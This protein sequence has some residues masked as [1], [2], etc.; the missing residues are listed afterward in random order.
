MG[1]INT[2]MP[3]HKILQSSW[4]HMP[5]TIGADVFAETRDIPLRLWVNVAMGIVKGKW[6]KR[7][8]RLHLRHLS[9]AQL[10]DIGLTRSEANRESDK[11][12]F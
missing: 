11:V 5:I 8:S 2:I 3:N 7:R 10:R 4:R 9:D 12:W 1:T 6:Q